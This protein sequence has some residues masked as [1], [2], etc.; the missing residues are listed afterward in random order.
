MTLEARK[1]VFIKLGDF[2]SEFIR[3]SPSVENKNF[4]QKLQEKVNISVHYN[5]W[6]TKENIHFLN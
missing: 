6:F 5:G 4:H 2:L 3:N 1:E